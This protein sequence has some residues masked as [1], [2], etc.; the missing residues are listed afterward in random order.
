[1]NG[2]KSFLQ[3]VKSTA[4]RPTSATCYERDA[5]LNKFSNELGRMD[6]NDVG[7]LCVRTQTGVGVKHI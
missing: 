5:R 7:L 2:C 6:K 3:V 1:M 4:C